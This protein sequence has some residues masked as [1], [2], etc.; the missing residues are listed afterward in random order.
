MAR[1]LMRDR[2]K[3]MGTQRESWAQVGAGTRSV[4]AHGC[5]CSTTCRAP[6]AGSGGQGGAPTR[7]PDCCTPAW[8]T[9]TLQLRAVSSL[10]FSPL[11]GFILVEVVAECCLISHGHVRLSGLLKLQHARAWGR[12]K[13]FY[14]TA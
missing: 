14:G 11:T 4:T 3:M 5:R 12:G 8:P 2:L 1:T 6:A 13:A 7:S 9:E 10:P